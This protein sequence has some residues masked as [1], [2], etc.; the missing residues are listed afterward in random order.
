M[1]NYAPVLISVLDRNIHFKNCVDSLAQNPLAKETHLYIALDAPFAEKHISGHSKVLEYISCIKGFKEVTLFKRE[2]NIGSS[3]NQFL[4]FEEIFKK[5][6]RLIFTEDDNIFSPNFLD[7][8]NQGLELFKGRD[9]IFS[10]SGYNYPIDVNPKLNPGYYLWTGFAA[11]GV[12]LWKVKW[13]KLNLS[14]ILNIKDILNPFFIKKLNSVAGHYFP[15][16]L[17]AIET[18]HKPDDVLIC[19]YLTKNNLKSVFPTLSKVQ[20]HGNDGGGE[21]K[22]IDNK[23]KNQLIDNNKLFDLKIIEGYEDNREIN[24]HLKKHFKK[25]FKTKIKITIRYFKVLIKWF[26]RIK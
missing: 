5:H 19:Y 20:N 22:N 13:Q 1:N 24:L 7:F 17:S 8:V 12:G 10:V 18:Q 21:H 16:L 25:K 11:W 23:Y 9:D 2:K 3:N 14:T 15:A 6:D 26:I 4:A